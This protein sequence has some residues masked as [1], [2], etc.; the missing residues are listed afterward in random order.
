VSALALMAKFGAKTVATFVEDI[1]KDPDL[2]CLDCTNNASIKMKGAEGLK[3]I[4][5]VLKPHK[6]IT[7]VY[8]GECDISDDGAAVIA[9]ILRNNQV[10]EEL[11]LEKN[12]IGAAGAIAIADSLAKNTGLQTL[13]LMQQTV[14]NFGEEALEHFLTMYNDNITLTKINWRLESRKSFAL[15]K[16]Q[17]RN[18]EIKKRKDKGEDYTSFLPDHMKAGY[19]ADAPPVAPTPEKT[20]PEPPKQEPKEEAPE[21]PKEEPKEE[22]PEAPT[23]E[24]KEEAPE[25]AKAEEAP[26]PTK[27]EEAQD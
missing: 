10:I 25:E 9:D 7:K 1:K 17:T 15:N 20:E 21:E 16:L 4:A 27:E 13:N 24:P 8:F 2:T 12:H 18:V 6:K 26:E 22:T 19:K 3:Q 23:E 11:N 5:E 14:K